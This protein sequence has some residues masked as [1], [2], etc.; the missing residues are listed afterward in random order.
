MPKRKCYSIEEKLHIIK[1]IRN[2]ETQATISKDTGI[3]GSTL[4]GWL[5]DEENIKSFIV[6]VN[7]NEGM[8]RKR[9]KLGRDQE[10]DQEL[11]NWFCKSR[12]R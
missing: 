8:K 11:F 6:T 5:K 9:V 4:R 2:G 1:R 7:S 12:E 10:L 3:A